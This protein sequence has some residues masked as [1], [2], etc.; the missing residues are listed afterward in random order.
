M[1]LDFQLDNKKISVNVNA[2]KPLSLILAEDIPKDFSWNPFFGSLTREPVFI[3]DE[4]VLPAQMPAFRVRG[5]T[6]RSYNGFRK[7]RLCR[8][9]ERAYAFH[10]CYPD[11]GSY[12]AITMILESMITDIDASKTPARIST[13]EE[14][15]NRP[16][17][18]PTTLDMV[19]IEQDLDDIACTTMDVGQLI[20]IARTA[21]EYRRRRNVRRN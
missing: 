17:A 16:T 2:D 19:T 20:L 21:A 10:E 18:E 4:L 6:I 3:D 7:T 1:K 9:I 5:T 15:P 8:D 14:N 11:G 12:A 13:P